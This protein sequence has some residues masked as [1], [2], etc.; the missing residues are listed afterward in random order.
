MAAGQDDPYLWLEEVEGERALDWVKRENARSL[1]L[2]EA[3][4]RYGTLYQEALAIVTATDRIPYPRFIGD[5]LANFWQD[6]VHVRGLWRE[7]SLGSFLTGEPEWQTVLDIDALAA[8]D[9]RNW[10]YQGGSVLPPDYRRALVN[11][12]DGGKDAH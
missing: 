2:L 11:L 1:A 8:A 5:R 4:Q 7:T 3:D 9:G 6:T 10:V 12:S